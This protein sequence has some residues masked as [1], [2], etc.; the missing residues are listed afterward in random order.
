MMNEKKDIYLAILINNRNG[1]L[2]DIILD[3][4]NKAVNEKI[5]VGNNNIVSNIPT[6]VVSKFYL[7]AIIGICLYYLRSGNKYS[8]DDLIKYLEVLIPDEI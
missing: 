3:V 2:M 6:D 1:I 8:K 7:G 4:A 5:K